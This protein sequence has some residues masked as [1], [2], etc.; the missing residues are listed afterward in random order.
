[1]R[2]KIEDLSDQLTLFKPGEQIMPNTLLPAPPPSEFKKLS[3]PLLHILGETEHG[4][5]YIWTELLYFTCPHEADL[6][7]LIMSHKLTQYL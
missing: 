4:L 3:T 1:M 7:T 5:L 6:L 2:S